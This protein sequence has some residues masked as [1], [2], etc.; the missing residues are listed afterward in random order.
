MTA[1]EQQRIA[2]LLDQLVDEI[3]LID[4][5][6]ARSETSGVCPD[7]VD[8]GQR[9]GEV[10]REVAC[11]RAKQDELFVLYD[12]NRRGVGRV[13]REHQVRGEALNGALR[14]QMG[15]LRQDSR[16]E[17]PVRFRLGIS[18]DRRMPQDSPSSR[19]E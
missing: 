13:N 16:V 17:R 18:H 7:E 6:T 15:N 4:E 2:P 19:I 11:F 9:T 3:T 5:R 12:W 8:I 10:V 14:G 1:F